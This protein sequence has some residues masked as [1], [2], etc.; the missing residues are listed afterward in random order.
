[1]PYAAKQIFRTSGLQTH[2]LG[3][4]IIENTVE[5]YQGV[6]DTQQKN[7]RFRMRI[8]VPLEAPAE[9]HAV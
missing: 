6:M 2:S 7:G 1:M 4:K 8:V 3:L 9:V 5:K